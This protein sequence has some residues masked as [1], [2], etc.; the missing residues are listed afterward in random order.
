MRFVRCTLTITVAASWAG[1]AAA[2]TLEPEVAR[3]GGPDR[4]TYDVHDVGLLWVGVGN[5]GY[6][7]KHDYGNGVY[8]APNGPS[9]IYIAAF[10]FGG[11]ADGQL[12]FG[13]GFPYY[14]EQ[15]F[16]LTPV[17]MSDDPAW[18]R[19]PPYIHRESDL[20]SYAKFVNYEP[21]PT[22]DNKPVK[23]VCETHGLS[24]A[25]EEHDD[26]VAF[27]Y[28]VTN[29]S[30]Y[31]IR[32]AFVATYYDCDIGGSL[33]YIDDYIGFDANR[34]M[35]Y[36]YDDTAD[37]A[38]I[39]VITVNENPYGVHSWDIMNDPNTYEYK[40]GYMSAPGYDCER[41]IPYDWRF[42][43]SMGPYELRPWAAKTVTF[44]IVAGDDLEHLQT[45][46][47]A[48]RAVLESQ[49]RPEAPKP[50]FAL[51]QN[52]PN[53]VRTE[54]AFKFSCAAGAAVKLAVYDLAGR[55]VATL[56]EG[57]YAAGEHT[58]RWTIIPGDVAPGVYIYALQ[59]PSETI[60]R[61]LVVVE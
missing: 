38:Y 17:W 10:W 18:E 37:N 53:P 6:L 15:W 51:F 58:V 9:N 35:P 24:W 34:C 36:M 30:P 16:G 52:Y 49:P 27:R 41:S 23:V 45:N 4:G 59:T 31:L 25:D 42:L 19:V 32:D 21:I 13:G 14:N 46:A 47:D 20:D 8:P 26:F 7:C 5:D 11:K 12:V 22:S 54:T 61:R 44:A 43:V 1:A 57:F 48:A 56:A 50:R 55:R 60:R 39:G 33:S 3:T 28:T 29:E 40:Y 2:Y